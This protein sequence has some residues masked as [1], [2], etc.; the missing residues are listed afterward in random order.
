MYINY[1]KFNEA[2]ERMG[3]AYVMN[4][5]TYIGLYQTA[6]QYLKRLKRKEQET[7]AKFTIGE[8]K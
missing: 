8:T 1:T 3:I 4:G 2:L 6:I 5:G 7:L